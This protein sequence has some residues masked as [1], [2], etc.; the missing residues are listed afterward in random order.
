MW[1][2]S[3]RMCTLQSPTLLCLR[4]LPGKKDRTASQ[5]AAPSLL[6][7]RLGHCGSVLEG[8]PWG[9]QEGSRALRVSPQPRPAWLRPLSLGQLQGCS[10]EAFLRVELRTAWLAAG[11]S[12]TSWGQCHLS[13]A[14]S[15]DVGEAQETEVGFPG[16]LA[17]V[18]LFHGPAAGDQPSLHSRRHCYVLGFDV[19]VEA[20]A[21][22]RQ[23]DISF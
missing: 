21:G 14:A 10:Q 20:R 8:P 11:D 19:S 17:N 18:P 6:G 15:G 4:V 22:T 23:Q 2:V 7:T 1:Q 16:L 5:G 12:V 3:L 13:L 9:G